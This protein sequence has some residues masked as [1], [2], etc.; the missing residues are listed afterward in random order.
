MKSSSSS[1][2]AGANCKEAPWLCLA[3]SSINILS[4][5]NSLTANCSAM[6]FR[7]TASRMKRWSERRSSSAYFKMKGMDPT[8]SNTK[9]RL[10][11]R[12]CGAKQKAAGFCCMAT[13]TIIC[14]GCETNLSACPSCLSA[15]K[16]TSSSSHAGGVT[17][18]NAPPFCLTAANAVLPSARN[19]AGTCSIERPSNRT[20]SITKAWSCNISSGAKRM[21]NGLCFSASRSTSRSSFRGCAA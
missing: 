18:L 21:T 11:R 4:L 17:Y 20:A 14:D 19:C 13:V 16:T 8:A 5:H 6:P 3:A 2:P 12:D 10:R 7:L 1:S 9:S 15:A